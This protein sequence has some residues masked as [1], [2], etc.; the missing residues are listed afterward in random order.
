MSTHITGKGE[1][2]IDNMAMEE[3]NSKRC[4]KE[5]TKSQEGTHIR[6]KLH[7]CGSKVCVCLHAK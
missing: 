3:A 6:A 4:R 5:D 7:V 2:R 1:R